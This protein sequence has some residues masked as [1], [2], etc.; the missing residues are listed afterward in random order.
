MAII[1]KMGLPI[2]VLNKELWALIIIEGAPFE[3]G[4]GS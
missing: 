2:I 4:L 1:L 3:F